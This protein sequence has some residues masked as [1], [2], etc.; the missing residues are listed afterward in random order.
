MKV[1]DLNV[2][3][4]NFRLPGGTLAH[5]GVSADPKRVKLELCAGLEGKPLPYTRCR[6]GNNETQINGAKRL[7]KAEQMFARLHDLSRI[8][9][10]SGG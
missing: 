7:E 10:Q 6:L 5:R 2:P 4:C 8:S 9:F 3:L 1:S